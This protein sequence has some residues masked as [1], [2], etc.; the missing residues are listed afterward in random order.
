MSFDKINE[1]QNK[2]E[3]TRQILCE[4]INSLTDRGEKLHLLVDKSDQMSESVIYFNLN[5]SLLFN[6]QFLSNYKI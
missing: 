4:D 5:K 2:I 6:L 1:V 3:E